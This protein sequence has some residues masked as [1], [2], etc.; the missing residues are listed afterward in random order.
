MS[1]LSP[2]LQDLIQRGVTLP[3][4]E[5]VYVGPDVDPGRIAPGV[6]IHPGCRIRGAGTSIGPGCVLGDEAP[7]TL[8]DCRLGANV[9]L[10]GGFFHGAVLLEG[11]HIGA[12]AHVRPGTLL[13]EHVSCG[14]AVAFKQ[15]V[16]LPFVTAGSLINFCDCL[17]AGGT[18]RHNHS[19][20]GSSYAHFNYTPHQDKATASL[21]GDVPRGVLLDQRPIFL[22]G[23]GGLVGPCRIEFGV[24]VAAGT[25]VR[26]NIDRGDVLSFGRPRHTHGE[27]E[28]ECGA[29]RGIG[30]LVAA[31]LAYI[32]NLHALLAWYRDVRSRFVPHDP[33]AATCIEGAGQQLRGMIAERVK[34]LGEVAANMPRSLEIARRRHGADLPDE[35]YAQQ[36]A[37]LDGWPAME[38][39]LAGAAHAEAALPQRDALLAELDELGH[40]TS[41][42]DAIRALP[43]AAK[44]EARA[45]LQAI[46]DSVGELWP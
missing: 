46:V 21:I 35:P 42:L 13:E 8:Q 34:R 40:N 30:H 43:P 10:K 2:E 37:F 28:H 29:Y 12:S 18:D 1:N 26:R 38:E 44:Q 4:P 16:L 11:V 23:Q 41:Y 19:E 17:M 22:G 5:S 31:N 32:G 25:I 45:W 6:V 15:T 14:H 39:T 9:S 3:H 20:I 36:Q 33:F 27:R 7:V 24:V